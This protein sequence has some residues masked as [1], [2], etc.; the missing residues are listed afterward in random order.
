MILTASNDP[1]TKNVKATN[2]ETIPNSNK[3]DQIVHNLNPKQIPTKITM[4]LP[5]RSLPYLRNQNDESHTVSSSNNRSPQQIVENP[6]Q[7]SFQIIQKSGIISN[8]TLDVCFNND[9]K[10]RQKEGPQENTEKRVGV[11]SVTIIRMCQV[12]NNYILS[13][14]IGGILP[15]IKICPF[16]IAD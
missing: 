7:I 2:L 3:G 14:Q 6:N 12:D 4:K 16:E 10:T 15:K 8:R 11:Y 1:P 13:Q 9:G 5:T